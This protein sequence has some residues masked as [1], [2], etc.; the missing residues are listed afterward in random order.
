MHVQNNSRAT[1]YTRLSRYLL[2]WVLTR[3]VQGNAAL[4]LQLA[5]LWCLSHLK[6]TVISC[7][8]KEFCGNFRCAP[9][10]L[11]SLMYGMLTR[12]K[13][14]TQHS[15]GFEC[16]TVF[17]FRRASTEASHLLVYFY[18]VPFAIW[19]GSSWQ[20]ACRRMLRGGGSATCG[21]AGTPGAAVW[22]V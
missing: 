20:E 8:R 14:A 2:L 1:L 6:G 17:P 19:P 13:A 3:A 18:S 15:A 21:T 11:S 10:L 4:L 16:T 5:D 9:V 7:M 12:M 22:A